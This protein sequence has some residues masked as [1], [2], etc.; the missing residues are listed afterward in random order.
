MRRL[1]LAALLGLAFCD[2]PDPLEGNTA[3]PPRTLSQDERV[4]LAWLTYDKLGDL[5][6]EMLV[7]TKQQADEHAAGSAALLERNRVEMRR[8]VPAALATGMGEKRSTP[9]VTGVDFTILVPSDDQAKCALWAP[10]WKRDSGLAMASM[11][12]AGLRCRDKYWELP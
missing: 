7:A 4:Q 11:G 2:R 3:A 6:T 8:R 12:F 1:R 10:M 9:Y 5:T